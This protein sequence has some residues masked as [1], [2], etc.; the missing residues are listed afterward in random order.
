MPL[1]PLSSPS[2]VR[3]TEPITSADE[4]YFTVLCQPASKIDID[5]FQ[6]KLKAGEV[7][8][9]LPTEEALADVRARL[10]ALEFV[11]TDDRMLRSQPEFGDRPPSELPKPLA[12]LAHGSAELFQ[13]VFKTTLVKLTFEVHDNAKP[14]GYLSPAGVV[15]AD[16]AARP[17][18]RELG[19]HALLICVSRPP[20]LVESVATAVETA[21]C[22]TLSRVAHETHADAV[23]KRRLMLGRPA[24]GRGVRVALI[25]TGFAANPYFDYFDVER[26]KD[27]DAVG[28]ADD[29]TL[30]A[31]GTGVLANLLACAPGVS[32]WGVKLGPQV[33][34]TFYLAMCIPR[35]RVISVS[36]V[37]TVESDPDAALALE[38]FVLYAVRVMGITVVAATGFNS[39]ETSPARSPD[40]VAV[41]GVVVNVSGPLKAWGS[42]PAFTS[43]F[44][45]DRSVPDLCGIASPIKMPGVISPWDPS[46]DWGGTSCATP[47]A[48]GAAALLL[49]KDSRLTPSSV[50]DELM[51]NATD[52]KSGQAYSAVPTD[53]IA[54]TDGN[55]P[56]TGSGLV[57]AYKAWRHV[58]DA[59]WLRLW[60]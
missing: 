48:A 46:C 53:V 12:V 41:G 50:R 6:K 23:H 8:A 45:A 22:I 43:T 37:Q 24:N 44:Y 57:N 21:T 28:A 17:S 27:P 10:T 19:P 26:I 35:V 20:V 2:L 11:V 29:D 55:D 13:R 14:V 59:W 60:S 38:T 15:L 31:H 32:A 1:P 54:A 4:V 34:Q 49:Q 7:D 30:F 42:S 3:Q 47:Q 58:S 52:I 39:G 16:G 9:L 56:A 51:S 40:V 5:D 33:D 36:W 18:V 25:D